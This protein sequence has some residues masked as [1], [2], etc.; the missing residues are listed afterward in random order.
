LSAA[1]VFQYFRDVPLWLPIR[2]N[3]LFV[4][5]NVFWVAKLYYDEYNA[6]H[7]CTTEERSL[8][9]RHFSHM[10]LNSFRTL[11][12]HGK[13]R[14]IERGFEFTKEGKMN[15]NVH[16]LIDGSASATVVAAERCRVFSWDDGELR[17]LI[18]QNEQIKSGVQAAF[19]V[20]LAEK[21]LTTRVM[22]TKV[23][24]QEPQR[25]SHAL[26]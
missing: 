8:Y 20:G 22:S 25:V 12:K 21:L 6:E 14:D 24:A 3:A 13:W 16:V 2:W 18:Q 19:G 10:A 15:E 4:A 1:V 5:I 17:Q 9:D 26:A 11:L 7:W 23:F